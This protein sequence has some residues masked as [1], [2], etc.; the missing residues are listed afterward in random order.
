MTISVVRSGPIPALTGLRFAA[1]LMVF[2]SHFQIPGLGECGLRFTGSGYSGVTF[3][4]VLSGF[5]V[6]HSYLDRFE[7]APLKHS[8][9]YF[10]ARFARIY[11]LYALCIV[12]P[13][14][15]KDLDT[16]LLP[17][18]AGIQAWSP[19]VAYAFGINGPAWSISVEIF[20]YL[21]FPL[22]IPLLHTCNAI[23]QR[24]RLFAF[25]ACALAT[26]LFLAGY[27][28]MPERAN[29]PLMGPDSAHRWLYRHPLTRVLDFSLG[30]ACAIYY[31]RHLIFSNKVERNWGLVVTGSL[32][33]IVALM[34]WPKNSFS[35]FSWDASYAPL[36]AL[37]ILGT[38][39]NQQT[40]LA[41]LFSTPAL[42]L[43]G[44]S[45]YALYLIQGQTRGLYTLHSSDPILQQLLHYSLFLLIVICLSVGLH[46]VVER[47]LQKV[48]VSTYNKKRRP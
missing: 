44:E 28:S 20:L 30:I 25:A 5:I 8:A 1:A 31:K 32:L 3:F 15:N 16:N 6:T 14:L 10:V 45:S 47:P 22:L 2:F 4:F 33:S 26:Q 42:V 27:F 23:N 21:T 35:A 36:F 40:T 19:D 29:L 24:N 37:L 13:W 39:I 17:Y 9:Q 41:K 43:L 34:G 12:Y 18:L 38:A 48:I 11:P 7:A 46:K